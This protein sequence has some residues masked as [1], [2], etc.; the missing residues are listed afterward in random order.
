MDDGIPT[1]GNLLVTGTTLIY[2]LQK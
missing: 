2:V 1:T